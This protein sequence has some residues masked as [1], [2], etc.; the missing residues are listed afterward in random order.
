MK[1]DKQQ[2]ALAEARSLG[3]ELAR[4]YNQTVEGFQRLLHLS[5]PEADKQALELISPTSTESLLKQDPKEISW[6]DLNCLASDGES[7]QVWEQIKKAAQEEL[8]S[9]FT[10]AKLVEGYCAKPWDRARFLVIRR[11]MIDEWQP[12]GGVEM[13]LLDTLATSYFMYLFWMDLHVERATTQAEIQK[14]DLKERG[15]RRPAFSWEEEGTARAAAMTDRF[16]RMFMRT[17][18][19]LRDLRRYSPAIN[20]QNAGQVNIAEKQV[21]MGGS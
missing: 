18:R 15:K 9:G 3:R 7:L 4:V 16:N 6:I 11:V 2:L 10:V 5:P 1:D 20:I 12:R 19:A 17:L 21:N 8:S 13:V 14:N